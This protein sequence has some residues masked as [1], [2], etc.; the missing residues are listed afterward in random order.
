MMGGLLSL[1]VVSLM[2]GL[3]KILLDANGIACEALLV[4]FTRPWTRVARFTPRVVCVCVCVG[5]SDMLQPSGFWDRMNRF[6]SRGRRF[7]VGMFELRPKELAQL[8][9]AWRERAL[10][11]PQL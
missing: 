9:T 11:M 2:K 3:P 7:L 8:L 1:L 5:F 10:S 4:S 6:G